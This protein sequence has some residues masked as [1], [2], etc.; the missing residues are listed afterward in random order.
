MNMVSEDDPVFA[1]QR[2]ITTIQYYQLKNEHD[3]QNHGHIVQGQSISKYRYDE[4][5]FN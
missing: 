2:T 5:S 1:T 3:K 4:N